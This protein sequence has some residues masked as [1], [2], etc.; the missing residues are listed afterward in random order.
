M[1]KGKT[2]EQLMH[3]A[4]IE[5][6]SSWIDQIVDSMKKDQP[7]ECRIVSWRIRLDKFQEQIADDF[8][9]KL[10]E[11][12]NKDEVVHFCEIIND[13]IFKKASV[14]LAA[15]YGQVIV[16]QVLSVQTAVFSG[17]MCVVKMFFEFA[18]GML[19]GKKADKAEDNPEGSDDSSKE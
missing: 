8:S 17:I 16:T 10:S 14:H 11:K 18:K 4:L 5:L 19:P 6:T 9:K 3:N 13:D 1:A 2:K 15:E 7:E 12:L